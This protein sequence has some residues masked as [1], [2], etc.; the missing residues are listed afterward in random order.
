MYKHDVDTNTGHTVPVSTPASVTKYQTVKHWI[1]DHHSEI[2]IALQLAGLG[3]A[4]I[5]AVR[6]KN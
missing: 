4:H 6:A 3:H 2:S 1:D 5:T